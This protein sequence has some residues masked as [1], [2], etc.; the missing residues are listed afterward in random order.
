M[1]D[2]IDTS[3]VKVRNFGLL[4]GGLCIALTLLF[5]WKGNPRWAWSTAGALFFFLTAFVGYPVLRPVYVVWMRFAFVLAW[6]NTRVLLG[7]FFFL[8]LTPIGVVMRL[9]GKDLLEKRFDRSAKTYWQKREAEAVDKSRY[10][11]LF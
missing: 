6:V 1:T 7:L 4:F 9:T 5:L 8:I 10:E 11:R 3:R 2:R